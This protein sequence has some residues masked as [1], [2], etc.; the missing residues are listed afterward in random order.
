AAA[1]LVLLLAVVNVSHLFVARTLDRGRDFCVRSMLGA[2]RTQIAG[3]AVADVLVLTTVAAAAS[4]AI[5]GRAVNVIR[6]SLPEGVGRWIAGWSS[7]SVDAAGVLT[8]MAVEAVVAAAIATVVAATGLTAARKNAGSA[9]RVTRRSPWGRRLL[10]AS[11][12]T[13][14]ATLLLGASVM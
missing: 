10:V 7:L 2:S 6:A 9:A 5:A 14:A 11:E 8:G 4:A 3:G 13:L 1:L 12:M